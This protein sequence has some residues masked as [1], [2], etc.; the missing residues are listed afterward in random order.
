MGSTKA[1][2]SSPEGTSC[3]FDRVPANSTAAFDGL[4][5]SRPATSPLV[6]L[7]MTPVADNISA[8]R[9]KV[10]PCWRVPLLPLRVPSRS[11]LFGVILELKVTLQIHPCGR[12]RRALCEGA[13]QLP[14]PLNCMRN[15]VMHSLVSIMVVGLVS[16]IAT[17]VALTLVP[18]RHLYD[19]FYD[20]AIPSRK[21]TVSFKS[22]RKSEGP[23]GGL[24]CSVRS[25]RRCLADAYRLCRCR[26]RCPDA[27][28]AA[29]RCPDAESLSRSSIRIMQMQMHRCLQMPP[30]A[31]RCFQML[32]SIYLIAFRRCFL[33]DGAA[34]PVDKGTVSSCLFERSS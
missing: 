7:C 18:S 31:S 4:V 3:A 30:D 28:Y 21:V 22:K 14:W 12:R 16:S 15:N 9:R 5:P 10:A 25:D 6:A 17:I 32:T 23:R 1:F 20:S 27:D 11:E 34:Q 2:R 24:G 29:C 26:C 19:T 33:V 8:K 13:R